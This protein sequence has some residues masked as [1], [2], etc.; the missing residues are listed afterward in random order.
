VYAEGYK[1]NVAAIRHWLKQNIGNLLLVGRNGMHVSSIQDD[2]KLPAYLSAQNLFGQSWD[3][4]PW[5]MPNTSKMLNQSKA[6]VWF[7][8]AYPVNTSNLTHFF[9]ALDS[10]ELSRQG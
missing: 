8:G 1:E 7:Q 3:P 9:S 10:R 2:S 6:E 5:L 4:P